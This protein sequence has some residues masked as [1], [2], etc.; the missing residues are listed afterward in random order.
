MRTDPA[1]VNRHK[2]VT[3]AKRL[4]IVA[5]VVAAAL[6]M[7]APALGFDG[8]RDGYVLSSGPENVTSCQ[9][10][11]EGGRRHLRCLDGLECHAA[12]HGRARRHRETPSRSVTVPAAPAA[13]PATTTRRSTCR[14]RSQAV[15]PM[16]N[17]DGDDAFSENFIGCS[18]CHWGKNPGDS[19]MGGAMH[20]VPFANMANADICGQCHSRYSNS[21]VA[22][23]ELRRVLGAQ[24][25]HHRDVQPAGSADDDPGVV[26][27]SDHRL[28]E[29]PDA[30]G[31]HQRHAPRE[32]LPADDLLQGCRG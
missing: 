16:V 18:A 22:Y 17:T 13:T 11:H 32:R 31:G 27:F 7:A 23:R 8:Y 12:F 15:Y 26:A 25:V 10:C 5:L 1:Q 14:T 28:P 4:M 21:T 6:V 2:E 9:S 24:A 30:H 29:H 19:L 20:R 3:M